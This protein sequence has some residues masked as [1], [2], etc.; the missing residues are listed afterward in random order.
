MKSRAAKLRDAA[1]Q[2]RMQDT[3]ALRMMPAMRR[4]IARAMRAIGEAHGN[5]GAQAQAL[6]EHVERVERIMGRLWSSM[7]AGGAEVVISDG[8]KAAGRM[9]H[10]QTAGELEA[11]FRRRLS[12]WIRSYGAQR[13]TQ[14]ASTTREDAERIINEAVA[15]GVAEGRGQTEIGA[16]IRSA[17]R[18]RGGELSRGRSRMIARTEAHTAH[19]AGNQA[20]AEELQNSGI[21]ML[22]EWIASDDPRTR[23][24]HREADGQRVGIHQPFIVDGE[25]LMYPGDMNGRAANVINCRCASVYEVAD[26]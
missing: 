17:I 8:Q 11:G 12:D 26:E 10:K 4:E 18:E 6:A 13:V 1:A 25:E 19:Q 7:F 3:A 2:R 9:E 24:P 16:A 22:K 15:E 23:E 20:G 5:P 21:P 14:I